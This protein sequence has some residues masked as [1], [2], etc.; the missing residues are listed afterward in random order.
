MTARERYAGGLGALVLTAALLAATAGPAAADPGAGPVG[1][2]A[3]ASTGL[4]VDA[5]GS[6]PL[7]KV[8]AAAYLLADLTTGEVLAAKDPH[9]HLRP[10]STLK[11]LT[12]MALLPRLDPGTVY[13][14]QWADAN[15]EGSRAG[16]VP[17]ATYTVG[18]LFQAL[19]LVSGNDAASALAHAAGGVPQTVAAMQSTARSLGAL[20]TTVR[21][22]SGLDAPGQ[23]TSAYDLAVIARAAMARADFR[24]YVTTVKAQ[25]PGKMPQAGH[26]RKTF[27]IYTQ[28]RL[29]LNYPGAIGIK[30]GFT[31]KARGTFVGAASRGGHTLIATVL[32]SGTGWEDSAALL[33]WGF[34]NRTLARPV[35]TL[36]A[37]APATTGTSVAAGPV[38]T[39][40]HQVAAA[41][42]GGGLPWWV[43]V[44][45]G[46]LLVLVLLRARVLLVRRRR[47]A[48]RSPYGRLPVARRAP[49]R[50]RLSSRSAIPAPAAAPS[51]TPRTVR[52]LGPE[53]APPGA[54][55]GT[56]S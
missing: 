25:F 54:V 40:Q 3:L 45:L 15:A 13:T 38:R 8:N 53:D 33:T 10:A 50:E 41:G 56:G 43:T 55:T 34:H 39:A 5:P 36:Q 17:D 19:F 2:P 16:I 18:Q 52:V 46:A 29:L 47:A 9:G 20:D 12:A 27:Q 28:D 42:A 24:A 26:V 48:R 21:N 49:R 11:V 44:P 1:G 37:V 35:G 32:H 23:Y 30:T 22:P 14:A 4:V 6:Q 7:P 51:A 31:T